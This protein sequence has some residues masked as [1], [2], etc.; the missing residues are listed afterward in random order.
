[1]GFDPQRFFIGVVDLFSVLLPGIIAV[2]LLDAT[3][4]P[5]VM[6]EAYPE[7][8]GISAV[9]ALLVLGYL[10]GH[11][12][13]LLGAVILDNL[14]YERLRQWK[15]DRATAPEQGRSRSDDGRGWRGGA[16]DRVLKWWAVLTGD[17]S[18]DGA[19]YAKAKALQAESLAA[20]DAGGT[21]N[22]FQWS[23]ARLLLEHPTA[24]ARVE[25]FEADSK[26]FRSLAVLLLLIA[27]VLAWQGHWPLALIA[28]ALM[29][30]AVW[31]YAD[32]RRKAITQSYR[33]VITLEASKKPPLA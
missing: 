16:L 18:F 9:L 22:V 30:L 8:S 26:F 11:I 21:M 4:A 5:S 25:R 2:Y 13:F 20:I 15:L 3:W 28:L 19:A 12:I 17:T 6:G 27:P 33:Y 29:G 24:L 7:L 1:M 10:T 32:Q 31:R 14:L 23:R